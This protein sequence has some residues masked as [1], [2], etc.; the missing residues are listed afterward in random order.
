MRDKVNLLI[1]KHQL[2]GDQDD[3]G[4]NPCLGIM[5]LEEKEGD[6]EAIEFSLQVSN[7]RKGVEAC[8][9]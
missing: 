3:L 7:I 1:N 6:S 4:D 5:A 9:F 8:Y 2:E